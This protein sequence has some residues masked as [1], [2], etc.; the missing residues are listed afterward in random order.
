MG[1]NRSR[2]ALTSGVVNPPLAEAMAI[3]LWC[4]SMLGQQL[5]QCRVQQARHFIN[6]RRQ[7][8]VGDGSIARA[9]NTPQKQELRLH[10]SLEQEQG[11]DE[12]SPSILVVSSQ[13]FLTTQ[14]SVCVCEL[15]RPERGVCVCVSLM[16]F[17]SL[18]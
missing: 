13:A 11:F 14:H 3:G 15:R 8:H 6:W 2:S 10:L 16:R 1:E 17:S 18:N 12:S 9:C 4:D 7:P 5:L